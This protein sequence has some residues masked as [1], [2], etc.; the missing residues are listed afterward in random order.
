AQRVAADREQRQLASQRA[1]SGRLSSMPKP[2]LAVLPGPAAGAGLSLALACD[3]RW[4]ADTAVLTTA[5]SNVAL[6]GDYGSAWFLTHLVGP[7]KAQELLYLTERLPA[8]RAL[9]LG[10]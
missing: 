6:S 10:L 1:T 4:A 8:Q 5:F 2:T 3:L 7:A 9:A